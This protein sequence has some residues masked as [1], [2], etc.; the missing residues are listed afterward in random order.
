MSDMTATMERVAGI[1]GT[2]QSMNGARPATVVTTSSRTGAPSAS[3]AN[4]AAALDGATSA[5]ESPQEASMQRGHIE[6]GATRL[7][8]RP[9][10]L[11]P[12]SGYQPLEFRAS[13]RARFHR[14]RKVRKLVPGDVNVAPHPQEAALG[15]IRGR[16]GQ[17]CA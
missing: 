13:D 3:S 7:E 10:P 11:G 2:L 16:P 6:V 4:F 8:Q 17:K 15:K 12:D 1:I 14:G 5:P 9:P